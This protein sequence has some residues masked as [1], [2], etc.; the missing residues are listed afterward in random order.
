MGSAPAPLYSL[1]SVSTKDL[2]A[3]LLSIQLK[4]IGDP[5]LHPGVVNDAMCWLDL[6]TPAPEPAA[7]TRR[8]QE[9]RALVVAADADAKVRAGVPAGVIELSVLRQKPGMADCAVAIA[10]VEGTVSTYL[11]T[12]DAGGRRMTYRAMMDAPPAY[13]RG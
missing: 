2:P 4:H 1:L 6:R 8:E 12:V 7:G 3:S 11:L 13:C 5:G 10:S 9:V